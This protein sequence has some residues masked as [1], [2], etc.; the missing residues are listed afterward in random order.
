MRSA[1]RRPGIALALALAALCLLPVA[2]ARGAGAPVASFSASPASALTGDAITFT[3]TSSGDV[4][5][6]AWDLDADGQFNDGTEATASRAYA[7]PGRYL[8]SLRVSGPTGT[9]TQSQLVDVGNRPPIASFGFT[10]SAPVTDDVVMFAAAA[11]D[12]DGSIAAIS[13]DLNGDGV[14]SD[15]TG[16][17][18][19]RAFAAPG[20]YT[21]AMAV[22]DS[23]GATTVTS[24]GVAV[25]LRPPAM[26]QPFPIVRLTT[27][28]TR[29]GVR[30]LRLGVVAPPGSRVTVRCSGRGCGTSD[31][32]RIVRTPARPLRFPALE[33]RMRAGVVLQV[34]VAAPGKIGK[35][36]RFRLRRAEPPDRVDLCL[37][38]GATRPLPS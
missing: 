19:S 33:H 18:A 15:A 31:Q 23:S 24:E 28:A 17:V 4:T 21:V 6:F 2:V 1:H 32:V 26:L 7:A 12:P 27:R 8:V 35:Y 37:P 25:A 10:P 14:F 11:S 13:W 29:R 20:A 36:T 38:P 5:A 22:T 34:R 9:A 3:S 16:P 30:V